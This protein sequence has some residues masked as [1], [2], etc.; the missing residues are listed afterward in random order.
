MFGLF[1]NDP[2]PLYSPVKMQIRLHAVGKN[3]E[4]EIYTVKRDLLDIRC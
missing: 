1:A 2:K 3:N 4:K